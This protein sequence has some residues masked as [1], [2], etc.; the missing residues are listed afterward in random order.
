[1]SHGLVLKPQWCGFVS[2]FV[3]LFPSRS[4]L[5]RDSFSLSNPQLFTGNGTQG[6]LNGNVPVRFGVRLRFLPQCVPWFCLHFRPLP[7]AVIAATLPNGSQWFPIRCIG[8]ERLSEM[9]GRYEKVSG[10]FH[11][12]VPIGSSG[13]P[14]SMS[15][16]DHDR[17]PNTTL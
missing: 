12:R 13:E 11:C 2:A 7:V 6:L 10:I 16:R 3:L 1:M 9:K 5:K 15:G 14:T 4:L 17:D 8:K